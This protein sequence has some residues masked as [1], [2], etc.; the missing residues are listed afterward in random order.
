MSHNGNS[1]CSFQLVSLLLHYIVDSS[2]LVIRNASDS[3]S[4]LRTHLSD[5]SC[6]QSPGKLR[7][8]TGTA[9]DEGSGC[10]N[11]A[12]CPSSALH[13]LSAQDPHFVRVLNGHMPRG[14]GALSSSRE[15]M[16]EWSSS[17][18]VIH[19]HLPVS[20]SGMCI[21]PSTGQ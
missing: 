14:S 9:L 1:S 17:I 3:F 10:G 11:T 5:V 12:G 13:P 8:V 18:L 21:T 4:V 6:T 20:G 16:N 15:R 7:Q 2:P 19:S